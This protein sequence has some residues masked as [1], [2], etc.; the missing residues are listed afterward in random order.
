MLAGLEEALRGLGVASSELVVPRDLGGE[1]PASLVAK[2][3]RHAC[4]QR[5]PSCQARILVRD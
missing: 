1:R 2:S 4:V 5:R 3:I